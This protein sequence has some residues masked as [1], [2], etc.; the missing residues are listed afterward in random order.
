M[1]SA[2]LFLT[3]V[4]LLAFLVGM[5]CAQGA[6]NYSYYVPHVVT[7]PEF[8]SANHGYTNL[9]VVVTEDDTDYEIDQDGDGIYETQYSGLG[10]GFTESYY[11]SNWPSPYGTLSTGAS[12]RSNKPL[13]VILK[14]VHNHFGT[15]DAAFM[16]ASVL[17]MNMWGNE[18]VVPANSTYLYI[19]ARSSATVSVTPP[20]QA[21]STQTILPK[22]N[23][24]LANIPSGSRILADV[25]VYVLAVNCQPDQNFPWMYNVLPISQIGTD[26]YHDATYGAY[27]VSWSWPTDP[28]LW[29]TA[30]NNGTEVYIDENLDGNPEYIYSLNESES[31]PYQN[32]DQG[33]H[34]WSNEKIYIVYVENWA[35]A[36]IG[37]YGGAAAEY[38]PTSSFGNDYVVFDVI[39]QRG[40]PENNPRVFILASQDNTQ[41][42]VDFNWD[43]I[44]GTKVLNR[45]EVWTIKWPENPIGQGFGWSAHVWSNKG[46]QV[47][48][49]T[50]QSSPDHPGVNVAYTAIPLTKRKLKAIWMYDLDKLYP[51]ETGIQIDDILQKYKEWGINHIF[52]SINPFNISDKTKDFINLCISKEISVDAMILEDS[53]FIDPMNRVKA[54]IH[55]NEVIN[56]VNEGVNFSGIHIDVEPHTLSKSWIEFLFSAPDLMQKYNELIIDIRSLLESRQSSLLFSAAIVPWYNELTAI[57]PFLSIFQIASNLD[58]VVIMAYDFFEVGKDVDSII[59][60]TRDEIQELQNTGKGVVIGLSRREFSDNAGLFSTLDQIEDSDDFKEMNSFW[61]T[62]IFSSSLILAEEYGYPFCYIE[63]ASPIT[64]H[65]TDSLGR[66][67]YYQGEVLY[68]EIPG[69]IY[70]IIMYEGLET[71]HDLI[72]IPFNDDNPY[73]INVVPDEEADPEDTFSLTYTSGDIFVVLAE[74]VKKKHIPQRPYLTPDVVSKINIDPDTINLKSKGKY[75]TCYIELPLGLNVDNIDVNS[76]YF[77]NIVKAEDTPTDIVDND[78][79]GIMELMVKFRRS[80]VIELLEPSSNLTVSVTGKL[81]NGTVFVGNDNIKV[82]E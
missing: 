39:K 12:V 80:G 53:S 57:S 65:V 35:Q 52:L 37:K 70:R 40:L 26:Y 66:E 47:I 77:N 49:R 50:D 63:G 82:K 19:F 55:V 61:G 21:P 27:D 78:G 3:S 4:L 25:P 38:L 56:L 64:L 79:N 51:G 72:I 76:I 23:W 68:N 6:W 16:F 14:F 1:K 10:A 42:N 31:V 11:R 74:N 48:Y 29:I 17:P 32:P 13:Q 5:V 46:I 33:T 2:K 36:Y 81:I 58:Y 7:G 20:G 30:I 54:L 69:A 9:H 62:S 41:V 8:Y 73:S 28:K 60:W 67:I 45:G 44:D 59:A 24:K 22:T 18:F 75:I 34:I 71:P 43:G 15:Y